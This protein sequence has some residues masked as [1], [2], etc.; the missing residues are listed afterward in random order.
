MFK[1]LSLNY[2]F[3]F[4][5]TRRTSLHMQTFAMSCFFT[6]K[7]SGWTGLNIG[8]QGREANQWGTSWY[9]S[10]T[11]TTKANWDYH[12]GHMAA[13]Q[14]A[15]CMSCAGVAWFNFNL[16]ST[17]R[18]FFMYFL[19]MHCFVLDPIQIWCF[20]HGQLR[21]FADPDLCDDAWAW[22]LPLHVRWSFG[23]WQ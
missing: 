18:V 13:H 5:P 8:R 2:Q 20:L 17:F 23:L 1:W 9:A 14:N 16:W 10:S 21:C 6:T 22:L 11:A 4:F 15:V 12:F 3:L 19:F 7:S